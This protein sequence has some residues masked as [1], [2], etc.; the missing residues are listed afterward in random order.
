[1]NQYVGGTCAQNKM[2]IW[3]HGNLY[4]HTCKAYKVT[5]VNI[6]VIDAVP[7]HHLNIISLYL[8]RFHLL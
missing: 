7:Q 2:A 3:T 6:V 8:Q 5:K 4:I 1:M